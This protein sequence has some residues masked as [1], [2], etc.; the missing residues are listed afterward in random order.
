MEGLADY[1]FNQLRSQYR[2]SYEYIS[3]IPYYTLFKKDF[4]YLEED[5]FTYI[6]N[7]EVT[8]P[9]L[10]FYLSLKEYA[11]KTA[12]YDRVLVEFKKFESSL[13]LDEIPP[14]TVRNFSQA[15]VLSE[16]YSS[17]GNT[18][19]SEKLRTAYCEAVENLKDQFD[20][21]EK[22]EQYIFNKYRCLI[23][24]KKYEEALPYFKTLYSHMNRRL[25]AWLLIEWLP[26][27]VFKIEGYQDVINEVNTDL[28]QQRANVI[29][30]LKA[31]GEWK[32]EWSLN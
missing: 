15:L 14:L 27:A 26:E 32:E 16:I 11:K 13:F 10:P 5:M 17:Q 19:A 12:N 21:Q 8:I 24:E 4:S 20:Q 29:E 22:G 31:E 9:G 23:A 3:Y 7:N 30:Y 25:A 1:Y 18:S 6:D 28:D 2:D